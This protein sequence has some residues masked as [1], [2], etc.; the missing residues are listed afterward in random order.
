MENNKID[1]G[2][3]AF[4]HINPNHD[5]NWDNDPQRGGMTLRDYFAS[6]AL[7]GV[8]VNVGRNGHAFHKPHDIAA[9]CYKLADAMIEARKESHEQYTK[10]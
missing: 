4:P 6:A 5:G 7:K 1:D 3:S 10:N 9:E 2:G 8:C